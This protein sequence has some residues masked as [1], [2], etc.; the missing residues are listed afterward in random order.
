M[1]V[2]AR[3]IL[4][5][6]LALLAVVGQIVLTMGVGQYEGHVSGVINTLPVYLY[7]WHLLLMRLG[8][9]VFFCVT[10]EMRHDF[11]FYSFRS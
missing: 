2:D 7:M 8:L 11:T 3:L 1:L 6:L 5:S 9:G 10:A 4:L